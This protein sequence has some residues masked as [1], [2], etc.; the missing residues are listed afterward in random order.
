MARD[1]TLIFSAGRCSWARCA[2]CGYGKLIGNPPTHESLK[3]QFD[4]FLETTPADAR[5]VKVFG[6]GSFLDEAQV[7]AESRRY[8]LSALRKKGV[9]RVIVESRPEHVTAEK[10]ADFDGFEYAVAI[11]LEVADD[12]VLKKLKKGFTVADFESAAKAIHEAGGRVRA[13]LLANPPYVADIPESL[14]GSIDVARRHADDLVVINLLPHGATP[15]MRQWLSGEWRYLSREEFCELTAPWKNDEDVLLDEETFRFVPTFP[16]QLQEPLAGVGEPYLTHPHFEVW[17]DYL[18]RWYRPPPGK[19]TLL[20]LPCTFT[21]PYSRSKTHQAILG[22]LEE[23]ELRGK[24]HEV[25][26]SNAGVVPREF[27]ARY[28]FAHYDWEER[29]ETPEIGERYREVTRQRIEAYLT[30]HRDE[31]DTIACYL[32]PDADS[33]HALAAACKNLD[34][35]LVALLT[36]ETYNRMRDGARVLQSSEALAD[37]AEGLR[38]LRQSST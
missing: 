33:H 35:S 13:Y 12:A 24:V 28:P 10:L 20:F 16:R 8:L 19:R 18:A 5:T 21:K 25:M 11:G 7:P 14:G 36:D 38:R 27:E 23:E 31:Y 15:L 32:K 1:A 30:A 9:R 2:F 34:L 29:R 26:L 6:S 17:Q 4:S 37:L 22:V 3:E